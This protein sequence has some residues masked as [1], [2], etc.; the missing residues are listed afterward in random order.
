MG[1]LASVAMQAQ[2][3]SNDYIPF[4]ENEKSWHVIRSGLDFGC[5]QEEFMLMGEVVKDGKSYITMSRSEGDMT[6]IYYEGLFR[7][8]DRKVYTYDADRQVEYLMFDYS[9]EPGDTYETYSLDEQKEVTYKV[10]S[11]GDYTE[12]PEVIR[13]NHNP[14]DSR[15]RPYRY[16]RKWTVCRTDD[17]SLQKT[18]IEGVGS[19]GGPLENLR[20][21]VIPD[22]FK[23][24]LAY[25]EYGDNLYMPFSFRD[26]MNGQAYGC[27]LPTG[28]ADHS[29]VYQHQLTYELDGDRLHVYGKAYTNC[30]P[31]NYAYFIEKA[32]DDPLVHKLYFEIEVAGLIMTCM[33]LH[34]TDFY[35]PG[36]DPNLN[37]IVVDNQGAEHPVVKKEEQ[38]AYRP[39]IE[40]GKVW[41]VGD[42]SSGDPV[43]LVEYY[44]FDGDTIIDG[45]TCKQ[46]MR[47]RYVSPDYP[48]YDAISHEPSLWYVG[49]WREED[50][51][52]YF[53][54][55]SLKPTRMV[56]E[57]MYDFST[58]A[59]DTLWIGT[60]NYVRGP[61]QTGGTKGFK[62]A[63][64]D[65]WE[66][67]NGEIV[68]RC[69]PWLEG[70]GS[71]YGPPT[72]NVFNVELEDPACFLMSCTVCDEVIYLN[73]KYED[74]ATPGVMEANKRRIDFTHTVKTRPKAPKQGAAGVQLLYGEYSNLQ[75][76]IDL[77]PLDDTWQV[78]IADET[79]RT[80]YEKTVDAASIVGLNIDISDY[81]NGRYTVTVENDSDSFT[82]E[83][84]MLATGISDMERLADGSDALNKKIYNLQGQRV[85]RLQRGLNI[86]DGQKVFMK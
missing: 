10:L 77:Y 42:I 20:D 55:A 31:N 45:R 18:W 16:L 56:P 44:Y 73:D 14:I 27:D 49:A 76:D 40:E 28:A 12:G 61:R 53:Y 22:G 62:G 63:Y 4:V 15:I 84:T 6:V 21:V 43:K 41:K 60:Y 59:N 13:P 39:F 36:F 71:I 70:V 35:V 83:F 65:V 19:L 78:C 46:M 66:C 8:E 32:T 67:E 26:T 3:E 24:Y 11:V 1:V 74:G 47:Q 33:A 30:N 25:V 5:Y 64:R 7:E 37:Y 86:V 52:V 69:A 68:Y 23:D 51:K 75:L 29:Q 9:L 54:D 50:K 57:L 34:A 82:G 58:D 81:T 48:Y 38:I 85:S 17:E 80:V 72:T 2:E 79:G